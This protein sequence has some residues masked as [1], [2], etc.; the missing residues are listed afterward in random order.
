ML[1]K[2]CVEDCIGS[3]VCLASFAHQAHSVFRL[4]VGRLDT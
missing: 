4:Y 1:P 2:Y 3:V